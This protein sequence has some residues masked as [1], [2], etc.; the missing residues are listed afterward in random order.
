MRDIDD[1]HKGQHM[2]VWARNLAKIDARIETYAAQAG[3][4]LNE[5]ANFEELEDAL[6]DWFD[7][8]DLDEDARKEWNRLKVDARLFKAKVKHRLEE[9]AE[10]GKIKFK[11]WTAGGGSN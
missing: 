6:R 9:L 11:R 8:Q 7:Q 1:K 3:E 5:K 10:R 4:E 2:G